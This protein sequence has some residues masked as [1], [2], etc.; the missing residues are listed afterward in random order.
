MPNV[1]RREKAEKGKY[2]GKEY[3]TYEEAADYLGIKRATLYNYIGELDIRTRKFKRD[4]RRYLT[5]ADTQRLEQFIETPWI[6]GEDTKEE[7]KEAGK[8]EEEPLPA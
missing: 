1:Q 7:A 3:L 6:A 5:M 4:R 2:A 8:Q